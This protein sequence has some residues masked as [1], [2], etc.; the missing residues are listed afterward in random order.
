MAYF[1][2]IIEKKLC[3]FV[4]SFIVFFWLSNMNFIF[5]AERGYRFGETATAHFATRDSEA[6]QT[7][8]IRVATQLTDAE[9]NKGTFLTRP[10]GTSRNQECD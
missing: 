6:E 8:K 9:N 5:Y 7:V 3:N 1:L 10:S 4:R 2:F